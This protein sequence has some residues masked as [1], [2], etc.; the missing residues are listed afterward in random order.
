MN[1]DQDNIY[2]RSFE[3]MVDPVFI[4]DKDYCIR[5][6]NSAALRRLSLSRDQVIGSPCYTTLN[7][8]AS[9]PVWCPHKATLTDLQSHSAEAVLDRL[10]GCFHIWT[11]PIFDEH[12][13]YVASVYIGRD[14]TEIKT[15]EENLRQSRNEW[16]Q[17][18]NAMSDLICIVDENFKVK[19]INKAALDTLGISEG[20][21]LDR[22]C[23]KLFHRIDQPPPHCPQV[24]TVADHCSHVG[25]VQ[26]ERLGRYFEAK[27]IPTFDA[28]GKY[29]SSVHVA[30]DITERKLYEEELTLARFE[31]EKA[32]RAKS[33]FLTNMSHE[34]R[35]PLNGV[36]GMAQ[37]LRYTE[38]TKEQQGYLDSVEVSANSLLSIISDILDLSKIEAE[39][40]ELEHAEFSLTQ[41][42]DDVVICQRSILHQKGL[43]LRLEVSESLPALVNGDVVR[44][45]QIL[46]NLLSNAVKFTHHGEIVIGAELLSADERKA[47]VQL[48]VRDTGIGISSEAQEKIFA[49]FVQADPSTTRLYG[50]TGL[51]LTICQRLTALMGGRIWVE[52]TLGA[53]STFYV[54]IPF[55]VGQKYTIKEMPITNA[56]MLWNGP[57][58]SVL[59]A[60]DD[61]INARVTTILLEQMGHQVTVVSDG[62]Q[63]LDAWLEDPFDCLIFDIRM[64]NLPGDEAMQRIRAAEVQTGRHIPMIALT[65][66][67]LR[68]ECE[69]LIH[70][71]FDG[72]ITKPL[73]VEQLAAEMKRVTSC[74]VETGQ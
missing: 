45:K 53:G 49:P 66:H 51:G 73:R 36:I 18:F 70:A 43:A 52:S 61:M 19:K 38:L 13:A 35:T 59:L 48:W 10:G 2:Q 40:V 54:E 21:G 33:L 41:A 22:E 6:L 44:M 24:K 23:Y 15:I 42:I 72:C 32:N 37:L 17:T 7:C 62:E 29:R 58:L 56:A 57:P 27:T 11:S 5:E 3:A 26:I 60:E 9:P 20:E 67:A 25:E 71:G 46:L 12:G 8:S 47:L 16:E 28:D 65:A 69:R 68:L 14:I 30:H 55:G 63:A 4:I 64:P 31:A 1:L 50:G 39:R 74:A 34:I